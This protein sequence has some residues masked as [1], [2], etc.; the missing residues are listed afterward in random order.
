MSIQYFPAP[1][2]S[3]NNPNY[4]AFSDGEVDAFGRLRVSNPYTLFD[5]QAR[6][7]NDAAFDTLTATG[8]TTTYNTNQSSTSL[9]VTTSSG[10]RTVR[11]TFRS[12][13]YQPGKSFLL[14]ATFVM[15]TGKTNLSQRVGLFDDNNGVFFSQDGTT[16]NINI[17]SNTSGTPTLTTVSQANWNGDKMNGTGSSGLTL[18][19]TKTQ[20]FYMD[21]EWLGV[22]IVR[23][24]FVIGGQYINCHT[25]YNANTTN[26]TVYMTTATLPIRYEIIN[27]GVTASS[28]SMTQICSSMMSEGGYEQTSQ[29]YWARM[30][31]TSGALANVPVT[32]IFVPLVTIKLNSSRLGAVVIPAQYSILPITSSSYEIALIK[33]ATLT[34]ASYTTGTFPDVDF[35]T[36]ATAMTYTAANIAKLD[37]VSA[38]QQST[39]SL[40]ISAGYNWDLQ[41]GVSLAGVS[42]T[43]TLAVRTIGASG[44][45]NTVYGSLGFYDLSL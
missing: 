27:T 26:T 43:Y 6:Y 19:V 16:L 40:N 2:F 1:G 24:G 17:R 4:I 14:L 30:S 28:S 7:A 10:S 18:D 44:S 39:S 37:Y 38:T 9:N 13:S 3:Q 35:D 8:G 31:G 36:T 32:N 21:L 5:G 41:L 23:T 33:N 12:M 20:I 11:Q 25:F 15:G 42:D 34:G 22:G 45:A 29:I